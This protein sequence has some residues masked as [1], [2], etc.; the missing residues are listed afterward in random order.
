MNTDPEDTV[1]HVVP[2]PLIYAATLGAGMLLQRLRPAAFLPAAVARP[3]GWV[4]IPTSLALGVSAVRTLFQAGTS[5]NPDVPTTT[6]VS[7]GP[8][9]FSR[10][11]IYL[12][13]TLLTLGI[14]A[15]RNTR[16]PVLLLAGAVLTTQRGVIEPEERYLEQRFGDAYRTYKQR[17]RRWL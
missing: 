10:N 15:A 4:L 11:P 14:A 1:R 12:A 8:Y 5:P 3:L 7:H 2:P 17:V 6:I 16:W 9:R 13:F